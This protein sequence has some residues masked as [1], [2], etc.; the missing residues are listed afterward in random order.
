MA[1]VQ[2][3]RSGF[4]PALVPWPLAR[5]LGVPRASARALPAPGLRRPVSLVGR[6]SALSRSAVVAF[7]DALLASVKPADGAL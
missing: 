2:L 7:R 6:K 1:V 4:G 5:A 3:G